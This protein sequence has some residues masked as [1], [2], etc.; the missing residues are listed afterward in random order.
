VIAQFPGQVCFVKADRV[1][2]RQILDNLLANAIK[3]TPAGGTV[4]LSLAQAAG[5]VVVTVRDSGVGFDEEF[6]DK[7]F[8]PFTQEEQEPDRRV[9]GLG[10][11]LAIARRLAKL[12]G[13]SLSAASAG[14]NRGRPSPLGFRWSNDRL[15]LRSFPHRT[16]TRD[17]RTEPAAR[18]SRC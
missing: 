4:E 9:G 2:L 14:R 15:Q 11:G 6:A 5:H 18:P 17:A 16:S 1:R 10:L 7:L 12:Q 13:A 8:D 3:F